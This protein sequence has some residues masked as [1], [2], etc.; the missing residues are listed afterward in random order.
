MTLSLTLNTNLFLFWF[1]FFQ[2]IL[3]HHFLQ[4]LIWT[5]CHDSRLLRSKSIKKRFLWFFCL[6]RLRLLVLSILRILCH[7]LLFYYCKLLFSISFI[8][9][10]VY[11][12]IHRILVILF[13]NIRRTCWT[14]LL[15]HQY[16]INELM[17]IMILNISGWFLI[18][19]F[20]T[21]EMV[22]G[23]IIG[24]FVRTLEFSF[25]W[26]NGGTLEVTAS[27]I[28]HLSLIF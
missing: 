15:F 20:S 10:S 2:K 8:I 13:E 21:A 27:V 5:R 9:L 12:I 1:C 22:K 7:V 23:R 24:C 6:K 28:T 19:R 14:L 11:S 3:S 17:L 16:M 25:K 26:I 4:N 18:I